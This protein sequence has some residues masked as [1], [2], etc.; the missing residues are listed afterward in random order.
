MLEFDTD[1]TFLS[2]SASNGICGSYKI[3]YGASN[4][5]IHCDLMTEVAAI[6]DESLYIETL[7]KIQSFF[8]Q[9]KELRLYYNEKKEHLLFKQ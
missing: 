6:G 7:N 9:K 3:D 4:I 2:N 8:L 5:F 1:S